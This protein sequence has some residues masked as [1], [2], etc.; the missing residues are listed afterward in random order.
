MLMV[1]FKR[2]G[3]ACACDAGRHGVMPGSLCCPL[4]AV[5]RVS[6]VINYAVKCRQ[7]CSPAPTVNIW[8]HFS[9]RLFCSG[10]CPLSPVDPSSSEGLSSCCRPGFVSCSWGTVVAPSR[11]KPA[12]AML[13][14]FAGLHQYRQTDVTFTARAQQHRCADVYRLQNVLLSFLWR[15]AMHA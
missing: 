9:H 1:V 6:S 10:H 12:C 13:H 7:R 4:R 14:G 8:R 3:L 11:C 5:Q 15:D 2:R